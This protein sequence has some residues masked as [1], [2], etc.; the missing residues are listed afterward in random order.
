MSFLHDQD[1][2]AGVQLG[3]AGRKGSTT[4]PWDGEVAIPANEGGWQTIGPSPI[5]FDDLPSPTEMTHDDI[6]RVIADFV[7]ATRRAATAG[8]D[9]IELHAAHGYLAH[10]FLSP[11]SNLRSDGYGG[12]FEARTRFLLELVESMRDAWPEERP[13]FV[14]LSATDWAEGGWT[15]EDT[16]AVSHLLRDRGV[17]LID[18]SSGGTVPKANI[19]VGPGY[20]VPFARRVRT[21]VGIATGA[22]GRITE[23]QQANQIIAEGSADAVLLGKALLR[24][25][26]WPLHAAVDLGE[27]VAWPRQYETSKPRNAV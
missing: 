7:A 27:Q 18:C 11:L 22:V 19:P 26:H 21:G 4:P 14:R 2:L 10:A 23:P 8:F 12:T 1:A 3:H 25:P 15:L 13:L 17:D 20:Q 6:E 16:V 24:H 5:S 9:V